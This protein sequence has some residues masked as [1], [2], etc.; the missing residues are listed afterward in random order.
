MEKIICSNVNCKYE[1]PTTKEPKANYLVA[2]GLSCL[3]LFPGLIYL[4]LNTG[5][6]YYCPNC[7]KQIGEH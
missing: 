2:L 7:S 6:R 3:M 5:S 4:F 1:G